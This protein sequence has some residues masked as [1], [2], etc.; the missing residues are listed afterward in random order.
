MPIACRSRPCR[1]GVGSG[2]TA[3]SSSGRAFPS[4]AVR[5][6][7]P[8]GRQDTKGPEPPGPG[9]SLS[10]GLTGSSGLG[11]VRGAGPLRAV[12]HL[13]PDLV[14]LVEG[15]EPV[16]LDLGMV[17]EHVRTTLAR[18]EPEALGLVEPL[19]GAFDHLRTGLLRPL[20]AASSAVRP[21]VS[22]AP[23]WAARAPT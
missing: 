1:E 6:P 4:L 14:T 10:G 19:D 8:A 9:P 16:G 7:R 22:H 20:L 5:G 17:D 12:H 15:A 23:H 11:H 2:L 21:D 13:E 3:P 18:Q